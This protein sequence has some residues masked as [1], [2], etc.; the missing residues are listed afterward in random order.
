MISL[1]ITKGIFLFVIIILAFGCDFKLYNEPE[2]G[3]GNW[4]EDFIATMNIDGS[5]VQL[6]QSQH[7]TSFAGAR[8]YF[9]RDLAGNSEEEVILLDFK[10]RIDIMSLNGEYRR[11][12]IDSLGGV[13]YFNQDRTKMLLEKDGEIY[14]CNVDGTGLINLTNTPNVY[15]RSPSFSYDENSVTYSTGNW[16]VNYC[17]NKVSL[18]DLHTETLF[19]LDNN[20]YSV[21]F[22]PINYPSL[23]NEKSIVYN[24]FLFSNSISSL[25]KH[26]IIRLNL[27]TNE[28]TTLHSGTTRIV[29]SHDKENIAAYTSWIGVYLIDLLN[30]EINTFDTDSYTE[31][32]SFS[33]TDRYL[34]MNTGV[35]DLSLKISYVFSDSEF[36]KK[37][38]TVDR[39]HMNINE[40]RLIGIVSFLHY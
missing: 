3:E 19:T 22:L 2:V 4:R 8:P 27:E 25:D 28:E 30:E 16:D 15:D 5:D 18:E 13:Q 11:T 24:L 34:V 32:L 17:I 7:Q 38:N 40:D 29:Y 35:W 33:S 23:I 12:I 1:R 39:L 26:E 31:F 36:F 21:H 10:N 20:G 14:I 6:I 37:Y 9:V